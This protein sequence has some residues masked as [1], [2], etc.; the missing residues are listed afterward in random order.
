M[1][2]GRTMG[3]LLVCSAI[4]VALT[5]L[6]GC[7]GGAA[8]DTSLPFEVGYEGTSSDVDATAD[9]LKDL[10][11]FT[12]QGKEYA[13]PEG[14]SAFTENG[15]SKS[16]GSSS[17]ELESMMAT[18]MIMTSDNEG[19]EENDL[20]LRFD[21]ENTTGTAVPWT[22]FRVT[23]V[24]VSNASSGVDLS[25]A[26]KTSKG[27]AVGD[28][29]RRAVELYG[30]PKYVAWNDDKLMFITWEFDNPSLVDSGEFMHVRIDAYPNDENT[31]ES[32]D[33][34]AHVFH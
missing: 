4:F 18:S 3:K 34:N 25:G 22:E 33:I 7:A 32:I 9:E 17:D 27:L 15:W 30:D 23:G 13:L 14:M 26:F 12:L 8:P 28:T 29:V 19:F 31:I 2:A 24:E 1:I 16:D 20:G 5:S 10:A 21:V 6:T 11:S